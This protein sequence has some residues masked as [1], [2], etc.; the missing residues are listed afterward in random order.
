MLPYYEN[1]GWNLGNVDPD[2]IN[3][4]TYVGKDAVWLD[5]RAGGLF[6]WATYVPR[7][8]G[9]GTFYLTGIKDSNGNYLR[10]DR[11][12]KLT[13]QKDIPV[14]QFWSV[15]AYEMETKAF[16]SSEIN[17][18]GLSSFE[19]PKMIKNKDVSVDIFFVEKAPEGKESNWIPTGGKDFFL[20]FRFYG[21]QPEV[22][23][24]SFKP[25][26]IEQVD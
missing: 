17:R 11:N 12:Y 7:V 25:N 19:L 26:E 18:P 4:F 15:F 14:E 23:D 21:P 2:K 6:Y 8:L 22:F 5:D 24:K 20:M 13:V 10:A 9:K 16:I 1:S 3:E